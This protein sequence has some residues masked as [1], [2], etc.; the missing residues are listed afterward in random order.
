[1]NL[2]SPPGSIDEQDFGR[3]MMRKRRV[4]LKLDISVAT[5]DRLRIED[6]S[7]PKAVRLGPQAIAWFTDE[8]EDWLM[9]RPRV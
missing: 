8:V 1:M 6:R 5:L 4:A 3:T 7:F 2:A 9:N